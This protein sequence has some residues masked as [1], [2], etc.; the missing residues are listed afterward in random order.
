MCVLRGCCS[1][2]APSRTLHAHPLPLA[3]HALASRCLRCSWW[4][5]SSMVWMATPALTT[6]DRCPVRSHTDL[7]WAPDCTSAGMRDAS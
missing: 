5:K 4:R 7:D 3:T 6:L 2:Q 1:T